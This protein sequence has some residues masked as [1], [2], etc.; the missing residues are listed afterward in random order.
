VFQVQADIA[1]KVTDAL[2]LALADSVRAELVARPTA[3][4]EAYDAFLK[5]EA[6]REG[7]TDI[8]S[9]QR[10]WPHYR[11]GRRRGC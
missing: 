5:G 3:S 10:A 8:P 9:L 7:S 6:A 2:D 4:L 1:T 11:D